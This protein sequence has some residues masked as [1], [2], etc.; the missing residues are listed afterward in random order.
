VEGCCVVFPASP[1]RPRSLGGYRMGFH[2]DF[3]V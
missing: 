2:R 3:W 1:S